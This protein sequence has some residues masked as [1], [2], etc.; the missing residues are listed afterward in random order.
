MPAALVKVCLK[1]DSRS[2][3]SRSLRDKKFYAVSQKLTFLHSLRKALPSC[4]SR[5]WERLLH[6]VNGQVFRRLIPRWLPQDGQG[7][8]VN[9]GLKRSRLE[10]RSR[11]KKKRQNKGHRSEENLGNME[12]D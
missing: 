3:E 2:G 5:N 7:C 9:V 1:Y 11:V 8:K 4:G 10:K 12:K 6:F